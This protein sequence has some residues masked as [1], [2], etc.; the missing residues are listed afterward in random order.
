MSREASGGVAC[1]RD[2]AHGDDAP[3]EKFA[4]SESK[5]MSIP[6]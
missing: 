1:A 6:A 4:S 5:W 3:P 2:T